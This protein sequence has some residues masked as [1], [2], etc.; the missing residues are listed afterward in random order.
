MEPRHQNEISNDERR[1]RE[2]PTWL[3]ALLASALAHALIFLTFPVQSVLISPFAAAG[4]RAGDNRA[5]QG[6][7]QAMTMRVPPSV[8]LVPPRIPLPTLSDMEPVQFEEVQFEPAAIS[9]ETM[10]LD[11]GPGLETGT[12]EGDGGNSDEGLFRL[13]APVPRAVMFPNPPDDDR[14]RGREVEVWVFVDARGS[15]VPD[16]TQLRPPT[17]NGDY[18]RRLIRD[19]AEWSF[20]PAMR[21]GEPVATWFNYR[22]TLGG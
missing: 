21:D 10:G 6:S 22:L 13:V 11:V 12:G 16:S 4:P 14:L 15:V 19:A 5:A 1:R 3:S 7:M 20:T 9:G 8:P 18:N 2:R 17:P